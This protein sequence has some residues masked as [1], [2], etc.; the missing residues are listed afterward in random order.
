MNLVKCKP[1]ERMKNDTKNEF[2]LETLF[3]FE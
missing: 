3:L 1:A 2:F